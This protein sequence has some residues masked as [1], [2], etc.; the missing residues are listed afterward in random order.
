MDVFVCGSACVGEARDFTSGEEGAKVGVNQMLVCGFEFEETET[1][2][3]FSL[4][5]NLNV[6]TFRNQLSLTF[7]SC[8]SL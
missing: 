5:C 1:K 3:T 7:S 2:H 8:S 6:L 4:D